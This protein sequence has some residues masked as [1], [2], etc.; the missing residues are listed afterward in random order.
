MLSFAGGGGRQ[1]ATGGDRG[2]DVVVIWIRWVYGLCFALTGKGQAVQGFQG[3]KKE[4]DKDEALA[5]GKVIGTGYW[6]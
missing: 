1:E 2:G 5:S 4:E 3:P 6:A